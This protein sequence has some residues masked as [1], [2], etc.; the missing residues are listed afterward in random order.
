MSQLLLRARAGDEMCLAAWIRGNQREV[1]RF[2][3]HLVDR[4]AADDL[5]QET[6][7][8]AWRALPDF[9]GDASA[10]TWL[11]SIARRVCADALRSRTRRRRLRDAVTGASSEL[12]VPDHAGHQ[13]L[14]ELLL[15]LE[16]DRRAAFV[17]T[18]VIGL[19]Y[20]EAS[21]V[22]DCPVGTIRSRVARARAELV[23]HLT[24][25]HGED[26]VDPTSRPAHPSRAG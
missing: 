22:C 16:P 9:R 13:A 24:D 26:A 10:R 5:T 1:W 25:L 21:A 15:H 14:W 4:G 19:S 8:R 7:V 2:C 6:F 17:L 12:H 20:V 18:N 23:D 3:A 11:L